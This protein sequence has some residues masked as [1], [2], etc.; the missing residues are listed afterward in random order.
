MKF[1]ITDK[2]VGNEKDSTNLLICNQV[3]FTKYSPVILNLG[4][5]CSIKKK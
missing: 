4:V 2:N 1:S 3:A 5:K